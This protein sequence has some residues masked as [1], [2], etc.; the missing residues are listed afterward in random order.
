MNAKIAVLT[1][2][3]AAVFA[4][5]Q[6]EVYY[7]VTFNANG[8]EPS[9]PHTEMVKKGA[10][11]RYDNYFTRTG[12]V[13][14]GWST[15][16]EALNDWNFADGVTSDMT[17]Y[18]KWVRCRKITFNANGGTI[19]GFESGIYTYDQ[20][21][22]EKLQ[23]PYNVSKAG[24]VLEGWFKDPEFTQ[25]WDF[26]T[27][28]V[29]RDETL[30][31]KWGKGIEGLTLA[32]YPRVDGA[33][34]TR[35]LNVLIACKLLGLDYHWISV[36]ERHY[37]EACV[38]PAGEDGRDGTFLGGRI[39]TSQTYGAIMN[40]IEGKTDI[41]LRSTTASSTEKAAADAAGVKLAEVPIALDAFVFLKNYSNP[42]RSLT[43]DQIRKI[44]TSQITNWSAVGGSDAA[45]TPF[46]RPRNSGSEEAF[47]ELVMKDLEPAAFPEEQTSMSMTGLLWDIQTHDNAIG[48]IFKNYKDVIMR[49]SYE[50]VF[51]IDG[52]YP[53]A[54]TLR[55]R[56][57]PL[58]T[59]LYAIIRSDLAA[60]APARK[61]F[62]WLQTPQAAI[63]LEECGF[64]AY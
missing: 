15:D 20:I 39:A 7:T 32:N 34:S 41:I 44:Y 25:P 42:V 22:G 35:A 24:F 13:Q 51:A 33:T 50:P 49:R 17:L 18:A 1:L 38:A 9:Q 29:T 46:A 4:A 19:Y 53:D 8:G 23:V 28:V 26:M 27:D 3:V 31:A 57:Y 21:E 61:I 6:K 45:I 54:A 60:D 2:A 10:Q 14:F 16:P 5:C 36:G 48:Y 58:T 12:Y 64:L 47:R 59:A 43:L 55:D 62:D 63:V 56:S 30:W 40:L 37:E 11:V 52:V